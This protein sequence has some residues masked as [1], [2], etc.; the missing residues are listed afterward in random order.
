MIEENIVLI[1]V[2]IGN[3]VD[4]KEL[5]KFIFYEVMKIILDENLKELGEKIIILVLKGKKVLIEYVVK[6][7]NIVV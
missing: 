2:V 5:K 6:F 4:F 1:S 7:C 3:E